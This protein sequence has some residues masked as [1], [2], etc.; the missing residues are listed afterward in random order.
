M[1][2]KTLITISTGLSLVFL[3]SCAKPATER[4]IKMRKADY[5]AASGLAY[6]EKAITLYAALIKDSSNKAE[7][8]A[9]NHKLGQLLFSVGRFP[10]AIE[11][12]KQVT[13]PHAKKQLAIAYFKNAQYADALA[14]FEQLNGSSDA[15]YLYYYGQAAE[16]ANLY[17]KAVSLYGSIQEKNSFYPLAQ[18]RIAA[19]N[20]SEAALS[21]QEIADILKNA[22]E[23]K[24]Y[25][26]AGAVIMSVD[27]SLEIFEND[28]SEYVTHFMVKIFNER[29]KQQ[30]SEIALGYDSTY[31]SVEL[32]YAR[33]I[34]P[35][36]TVVS[37]GD[38]NIRDVS[39]YLNYPLYSNARARI[40]SMPEVA[41]GVIIEYRARMVRRQMVNK[42]DFV[43]NYTVQEGEPIR[44][45]RFCVIVPKERQFN[46]TIINK[47]YN[48]FGAD[49]NP[50]QTEQG[51]KKIFS[52]QLNNIPEIIP[53]QDMPP[54]SRINPIVMMS[55]FSSWEAIHAWWH[56]LY[57]D[58]IAVDDSIE[59]K[60]SELIADKATALQ[61]AKALYNFCAQ[62]IRYVAVE[63]GQAGYEPHNA[64]DI[65]TNKYGD[66]KDQAILLVAMLRSAGIKA[67]PVLISTYDGID[68]QKDFPSIAFDHCIAVADIDGEWIFM[69]PTGETVSFGDLPAMDQNRDVL[70]ILD[71]GHQIMH[72]PLFEPGHNVSQKNMLITVNDDETIGVERSIIT[73]GVFA[74]GQRYWLRSTKPQ[75]IEEVL[76]ATANA[77]A[78]GAQLE[79]YTIENV[80]D[81]D[82]EIVLKY[83]FQA[84]EFLT[85]AE[86]FRLLPQLGSFDMSS[87]IKEKRMYPIE[88]PVLKDESASITIQIPQRFS[89]H[90][91]P[92][93][94]TFDS[95]WFSFENTY[96]VKGRTISFYARLTTKKHRIG[97]DAYDAYKELLETISRKVNQRIMLKEKR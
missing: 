68:L 47:N 55:S 17:D 3:C 89:V 92:E 32:E 24:D 51:R 91:V 69:D 64:A 18:Q 59:K 10:Q 40:I 1:K 26:E 8:D 57:R 15:E 19:I 7:K 74:Q 84:P 97:L 54:I 16:K 76:E 46:Y 93:N 12:L 25:P 2:K 83:Q 70:V 21:S 34:K 61:K 65:F 44:R 43:S 23:Q 77:I 87:V 48:S 49:L 60:V 35:D 5:Y 45:A 88:F 85:K 36:G 38:K 62:D 4:S 6:T 78:P 63:Y 53:E 28:T 14:L 42:K 81:L 56:N 86:T 9:L 95:E 11:C 22:P 30:F 82:K 52:W 41:E 20:L 37:V 27:E 50:Q 39:L 13:D 31:E 79:D 58:K 90:Y 94:L 75:L 66:C 67:Y 96:A 71:D 72:T 80:D 73:G 29:G 33:T